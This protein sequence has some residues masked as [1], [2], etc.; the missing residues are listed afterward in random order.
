MEVRSGSFPGL[1]HVSCLDTSEVSTLPAESGCGAHRL[2]SVS[3]DGSQVLHGLP[4]AF[5]RSPVQLPRARSFD[6]TRQQFYPVPRSNEQRSHQGTQQQGKNEVLAPRRRSFPSPPPRA[7]DARVCTAE[8]LV[9]GMQH[10]TVRLQK[11]ADSAACSRSGKGAK[12]WRAAQFC[13]P[14]VKTTSFA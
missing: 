7:M 6:S 14:S 3:S 9:K 4:F 5:E 10:N 12:P 11:T 1:A 2:S 13:T 8:K